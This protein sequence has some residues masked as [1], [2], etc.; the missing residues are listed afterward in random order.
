D[1]TTGPLASLIIGLSPFIGIPS[2]RLQNIEIR[3]GGELGGP[4]SV[5]VAN[6][7]A[8]NGGTMSGTGTTSNYGI[9]TVANANVTLDRRELVNLGTINWL[10]VDGFVWR[11]RNGAE[12]TNVDG[13]NING[14]RAMGMGSAR[15]VGDAAA[16]P[17]FFSS[18]TITQTAR[19]LTDFSGM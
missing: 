10:A 16:R 6:T 8:W 14:V 1:G 7:F 11:L 3:A 12:L 5:V 18:G 9:M 13:F 15:M 4:G 19:V 17:S 2:V